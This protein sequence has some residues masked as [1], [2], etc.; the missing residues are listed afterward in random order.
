MQSRDKLDFFLKE[1]EIHFPAY[2][3]L[4]IKCHILHMVAYFAHGLK[5]Y[6]VCHVPGIF[7]LAAVAHV[8]LTTFP[9]TLSCIVKIINMTEQNESYECP[10]EICA[11]LL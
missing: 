9:M 10:S 4:G 5:W 6:T 3:M 8:Y 2:N 7:S 11:M 1:R